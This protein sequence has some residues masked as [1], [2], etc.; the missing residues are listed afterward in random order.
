MARPAILFISYD[1]MLEPLGQ[2]QVLAYVE[3]LSDRYAVTL[4]S[5][6]K[7]ADLAD[8]G[9]LASVRGRIERA[10]IEWKPLRYHKAPSAPA[11]A[12]DIATGIL[13][14]LRVVRRR[15]TEI[16]HA[17][18]YIPALIGLAVKKA[19]GVRFLFDM[20]GLWADER[21]DA[22]W[23]PRG[24]RLYRAAK[25]IERRLLRGADHIVTLTHAAA[26]EIASFQ[27]LPRSTPITVI[28]TCA[29]LDRFAP[30]G[31]RAAGPP[32]LGFVGTAAAWSMVP[33]LLRF[34]RLLIEREPAAR[35][36]VVNRHEW[37][38][39][40]A[41]IAEAG[42]DPERVE[43]VAA[44][45]GDVPALIRRMTIGTALKQ[46]SYSQLGCAPTKLAEYLGCGIPVLA[47]RGI[48][49]VAEI[50]EGHGV[51]VVLDGFEEADL[52]AGVDRML[53]LL[54]DEELPRRCRAAAEAVFSLDGG[55]AAFDSVY[56]AMLSAEGA[57]S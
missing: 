1:G 31:P 23:W 43:I 38:Y 47:N 16:I 5:F 39:F 18:S 53:A 13:A 49:D 51:G 19:T 28:P 35:L 14:A 15:R 24:G 54:A 25:A 4:L 2:S 32:V 9:R 52:R 10:G 56:R 6:E 55:V 7:K 50:V 11:T 41:C 48:G 40:R 3:R 30:E 34:H 36:L 42:I 17:R 26:R 22:G 44:D 45:H 46:P 8:S 21:V 29:D 33:E 20:R 57:A 37:D 27:Y 12:F